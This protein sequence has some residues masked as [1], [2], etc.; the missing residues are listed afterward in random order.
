[1]NEKRWLA[2]YVKMHHEKKVRDRLTAMGIESFLPVQVELRQWS[3][4]KKKVERVLIPMMIFVHVDMA[5]QREVITLP[6]I[7]HYLTLRGE[8]RPAEIP[9][10]Q[11]DRF[12]FML[13][14]SDSEVNFN[15]DDLQPGEKVRV[16]KGPLSG[17]EGELMTIEGKSRIAIRIHQLGC[18]VVEMSASM[19]EKKVSSDLSQ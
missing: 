15:T 17:L 1:M 10:E 8:H 13:D 11:M 19:V 7:L 16:I 9:E 3:D 6:S 14:Y 5:E 12:R 4:R 2:A 18:A